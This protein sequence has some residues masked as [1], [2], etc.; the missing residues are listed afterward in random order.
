MGS[1][2]VGP[3]LTLALALALTWL[4]DTPLYIPNPP[5][6]LLAAVVY[7]AFAGGMKS[8]L[9][10]ALI[11][12]AHA[13]Y[14]FSSPG[15]SIHYTD[16]QLR[17]VIVLAFTMPT[18]VLMVGTLKRR[19]QLAAEELEQANEELRAAAVEVR[20]AR[21]QTARNIELRCAALR[22]YEC[23]GAPRIALPLSR[24]QPHAA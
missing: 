13:A 2:T 7:S 9:V 6:I 8:G 5:H 1:Q 4:A 11:A 23:R 17:R 15:E 16:E 22:E 12:V 10:S 14:F 21:A 20:E 18:L 19:A 3:L 24:L